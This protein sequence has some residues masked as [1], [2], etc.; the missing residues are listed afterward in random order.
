MAAHSSLLAW[1]IPWTEEPGGLQSRG[2]A[3]SQTRRSGWTTTASPPFCETAVIIIVTHFSDELTGAQRGWHK[4]CELTQP[5]LEEPDCD[6][7][8]WALRPAI[9]QD[10]LPVPPA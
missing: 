1:R 6:L 8:L 3:E 10:R 9:N 5:G 2:V 7:M 4:L